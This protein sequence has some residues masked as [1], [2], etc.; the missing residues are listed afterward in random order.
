MG[1]TCQPF[2]LMFGLLFF[3]EGVKS[4]RWAV[5]EKRREFLRFELLLDAMKL[6]AA[7]RHCGWKPNKTVEGGKTHLCFSAHHT[8]AVTETALTDFASPLP[9]HPPLT[10]SAGLVKVT[11]STSGLINHSRGLLKTKALNSIFSFNLFFEFV[12]LLMYLQSV[13]EDDIWVHCPDIQMVNERTF[14]PVWNLFQGRQLG[15]DLVTNLKKH[16][17]RFTPPAG[18]AGRIWTKQEADKPH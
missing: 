4:P 2:L 3:T 9:G 11:G 10:C 16:Q 6:T 17:G 15:F 18:N 1:K 5:W 8:E 13:G 7:G 14:D 12:F